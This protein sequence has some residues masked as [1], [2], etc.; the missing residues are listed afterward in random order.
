MFVKFSEQIG[1][2]FEAAAHQTELL[3]SLQPDC[4][5]GDGGDLFRQRSQLARQMSTSYDHGKRVCEVLGKNGLAAA[6][7]NE[8][9]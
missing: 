9:V 8:I 4:T 3:A 1:R 6:R 2:E 7:L 5:V